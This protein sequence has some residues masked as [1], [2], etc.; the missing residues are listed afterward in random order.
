MDN[1]DKSLS[2]IKDFAELM[3]FSEAQHRTI[4]EL[5]KKNIELHNEVLELKR[6]LEGT[7]PLF[8]TEKMIPSNEEM[9]CL[10]QIEDFRKISDNCTLTL[11]ETRQLDLLVKNLTSIRQNSKKDINASAKQI[12]DTTLL[13]YA[14]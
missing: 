9:I 4:N 10:K 7:V 2:Q 6:L 13:E 3:E 14:K 5:A 1:F 11:D 8:G 12:D